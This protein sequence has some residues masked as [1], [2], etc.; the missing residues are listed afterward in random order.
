[1]QRRLDKPAKAS[2]RDAQSHT[3]AARTARSNVSFLFPSLLCI[4][5]EAQPELDQRLQRAEA[6]L[7]AARAAL[8]HDVR[9]AERREKSR[10][11]NKQKFFDSLTVTVTFA[12]DL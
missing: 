1:M 6:K 11:R 4:I 12:S 10:R 7:A 2:H 3:T 9:L 5:A 8:I